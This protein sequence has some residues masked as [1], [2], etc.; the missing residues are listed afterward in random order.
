MTTFPPELVEIIVHDV[1]HSKMPSYIRKTF[2][3]A[4][5]RINRTWKAVYA[6][7]ASQDMY[8]TNL[9]FLDYLCDIAQFQK[10]IIYHD[11]IPRLARTITCF[12]DL[13]ANE[14]E[15]AAKEVYRYLIALPNIRGFDALFPHV[16]YIS[17]RLVWIGIRQPSYVLSLGGIPIH[18]RYD[19]FLSPSR[20]CQR[21]PGK[22]RMHIYISM[23]DPGSWA[24]ESLGWSK[25]LERLRAVG[26]PEYF[27]CTTFYYPASYHETIRHGVRRIRQSTD[28]DETQLGSWD[29]RDINQHLWIASKG[30]HSLRCLSRLF[31]HWEFKQAQSHLPSVRYSTKERLTTL[32]EREN[33]V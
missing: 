4:C 29:S 33:L 24:H 21:C 6:P 20:H 32:L 23:I 11:F 19:R 31:Y 13:R 22:T 1:W 30:R 14:R 5:P 26:V 16:P 18:V 17:F 10:S 9:A 28:I 15:G 27:F 12:V 25:M 8:I 7:I 3:T 2:M